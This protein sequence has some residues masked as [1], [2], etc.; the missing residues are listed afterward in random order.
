M[1]D[2]HRANTITASTRFGGGN[3][4]TPKTIARG[5]IDLEADIAEINAG[6]AKI[7]ENGHVQASSGRIFGT[8]SDGRAAIYPISGPGLV[9][10]SQA[11]FNIFR[12]MTRTGGLKGHARRA[13]DGMVRSGN[14]GL[15]MTSKQRLI[16][17]FESRK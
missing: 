7:L 5:D 10:L 13:F 16:D 17:L 4:N 3:R 6:Q 8:H 11:E 2:A 15:D 1:S 14:S 9:N 12:Q